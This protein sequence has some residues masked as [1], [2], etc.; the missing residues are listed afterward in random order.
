MYVSRFLR[1]TILVLIALLTSSSILSLRMR[2]DVLQHLRTHRRR[3]EQPHDAIRAVVSV[4]GDAELSMFRVAPKG[5]V[6]S[7]VMTEQDAFGRQN[8]L[9]VFQSLKCELRGLDESVCG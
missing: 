9:C 5:G 6:W 2:L 8:G 4:D 7:S 3:S 1:L